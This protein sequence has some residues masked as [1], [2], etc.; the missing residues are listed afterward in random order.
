MRNSILNINKLLN[1]KQLEK[2]KEVIHNL[3]PKIEE[4]YFNRK[5]EWDAFLYYL[6]YDTSCS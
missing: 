5:G 4:K 6:P 3:I 1:K 2:T